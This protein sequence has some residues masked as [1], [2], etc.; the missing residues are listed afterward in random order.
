[1]V[2]SLAAAHDLQ[3]FLTL[4]GGYLFWNPKW[5]AADLNLNMDAALKDFLANYALLNR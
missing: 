3:P 1:V 5:P 2:T 4:P